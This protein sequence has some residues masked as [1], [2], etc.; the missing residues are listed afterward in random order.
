M[1]GSAPKSTLPTS[2]GSASSGRSSPTRAHAVAH[3]VGRLVDVA[4]RVEFDVDARAAVG[5]LRRDLGDA[6][7]PGHPFL[8]HLRDLGLDDVGGG[9]EVV[10][11]DRDDRGLDVRQFAHGQPRS[12]QHAE[13]HQHQADD[14]GEDGALDRDFRNLHRAACPSVAEATARLGAAADSTSVTL[15]PSRSFCVPSVTTSSP[16]RKSVRDLHAADRALARLDLALRRL[17]VLHDVDEDVALLRHQ[18]L[19]GHDQHVDSPRESRTFRNMP[20]FSTP[21]SFGTMAR[22][23]T[24]RVLGSTRESTLATRPRKRLAR[25][26]D[27]GRLEFE[28]GPH[29]RDDA[30]RHREIEL[31]RAGVVE[32]RDHRAGRHQA[33]DT[34]AAQA[35][36]AIER[37]A[38]HGVA[39]A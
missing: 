6:L 12:G 37:R 21:W 19:L 39:E 30:F 10:R 38:D 8:D 25:V 16:A 29:G 5:A 9:A 3:V 11:V 34:D 2:G 33:A 7:E 13:D 36:A 24:E 22:T 18:R 14:R 28:A 17:A 15:A 32:R 35:D 31:D 27:A 4:R 20:G 26:R 1:I 23:I